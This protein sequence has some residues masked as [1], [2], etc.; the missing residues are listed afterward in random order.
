MQAQ[1]V[2]N[3]SFYGDVDF[4]ATSNKAREQQDGRQ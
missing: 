4:V 1:V 3:N 2:Q